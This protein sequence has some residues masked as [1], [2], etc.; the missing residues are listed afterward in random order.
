MNN[1]IVYF[2]LI[3]L[4]INSGCSAQTPSILDTTTTTTTTFAV[5]GDY[6]ADN[7]NESAVSNLVKSWNP[8]FVITVGDNNYES[9]EASTIDKNIGKYYHQYIGN[10]MGEFGDGASENMF[11][12]S[13]GN[14][15]WYSSEGANP[16][17]NYFT[18]P[19]NERYYDFKKGS[20]HFFVIDSDDHEV[21]GIS[22]TS[23]Q[24]NW[25]KS[26]LEASSS[27]FK[28]VY[29]HHPPFSSGEHGNSPALDW[30]FKEWGAD[31]VLCGH[32][33]DYERLLVNNF[34]Y[35]IIGTGG[36]SLRAF[37]TILSTSKFRFSDNYGALLVKATDDNLLFSFY[38]IESGG[39]LIDEYSISKKDNSQSSP[40]L[41]ESLKNSLKNIYDAQY[42][43]AQESKQAVPIT[44]KIKKI[45][46]SFDAFIS[47][48]QDISCN[49]SFDRIVVK[50]SDA[51]QSL[52]N[53]KCIIAT[54]SCINSDTLDR[55][56]PTFKHALSEIQGASSLDLNSNTKPDVCEL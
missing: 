19:G 1:I 28:I 53:K 38:S 7:D 39:T 9:G 42:V 49:L 29:F 15:D 5:I 47:Q 44:K 34:P 12:P 6:G 46:K 13:L 18:L 48:P 54:K 23:V 2:L 22:S 21:D 8:D 17:L 37:N 3:L 35:I 4:S 27:K 33:H 16:Y 51:I 41:K 30:P 10:Y 50:L 36:R 45:L 26:S 43:L 52:E 31:I 32:D 14:H 24:A 56:L 40:T 25:L 20:V 55:F 11:F